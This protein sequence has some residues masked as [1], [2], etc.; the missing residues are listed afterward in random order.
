MHEAVNKEPDRSQRASEQAGQDCRIVIGPRTLP[1]T[2][3]SF[4]KRLHYRKHPEF[5]E[6]AVLQIKSSITIK[7]SCGKSMCIIIIVVPGVDSRNLSGRISGR[8][9]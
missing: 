5:S 3:Y 8:H 4:L 1:E 2:T 7:L 9:G 6:K